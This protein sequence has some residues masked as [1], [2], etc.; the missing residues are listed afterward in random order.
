MSESSLENGV[1]PT[2][3]QGII[4]NEVVFCVVKDKGSDCH[5]ISAAEII[6][7]GDKQENFHTMDR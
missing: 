2:Y 5:G 1:N 4:Q 3:I 7:F 6:V